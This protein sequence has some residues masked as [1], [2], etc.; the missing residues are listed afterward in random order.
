MEWQER[1]KFKDTF[2]SYIE[3]GKFKQYTLPL[4]TPECSCRL[5]QKQ[6]GKSVQAMKKELFKN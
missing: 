6:D 2:V 5:L 4:D 1:Q 3:D